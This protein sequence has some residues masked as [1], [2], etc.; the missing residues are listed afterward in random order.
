MIGTTREEMAAFYCIDDEIAKADQAA[1]EGVFASVFPTGHRPYYDEIRRMRA[2][3]TQCGAAGRPDELMR[4]SAS[5]VCAWPNGEPTRDGRLTCISSTGNRRPGSR[6]ATASKFR[7]CST[8]SRTGRTPR[9][10]RARSSREDRGTCRGD[11]RRLDRVCAER[12]A[13]I[14]RACPA[15]PPYRREDRMTMRFDSVIGPV[16]DL[17]GLAS[18]QP[19]PLK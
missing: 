6:P 11:A 10:S 7:S 13:R 19:W 1:I 16:S 14:T 5:A 18:R 17:A 4:C 9:C 12:K 15:W 8:I 3:R 2:S